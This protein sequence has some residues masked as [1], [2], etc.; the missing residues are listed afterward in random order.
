MRFEIEKHEEIEKTV[1][2]RTSEM[3]EK[4][5]ML[6]EVTSSVLDLLGIRRGPVQ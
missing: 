1:E 6:N 5:R 4:N 2:A 3:L